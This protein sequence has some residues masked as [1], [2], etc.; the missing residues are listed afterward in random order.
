MPTQKNSLLLHYTKRCSSGE[1]I[2][3]MRASDGRSAD[4][5]ATE[6]LEKILS[7]SALPCN[8]L[9]VYDVHQPVFSTPLSLIVL[10]HTCSRF[11][12]MYFHLGA[13]I[14]RLRFLRLCDLMWNYTTKN[15]IIYVKT[16]IN[17]S[18][19]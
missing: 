17:H 3:Q 5:L 18:R 16:D 4:A 15:R 8:R 12:M 11:T 14:L 1:S 6:A 10:L 19:I 7:I 9:L 2:V 13:F